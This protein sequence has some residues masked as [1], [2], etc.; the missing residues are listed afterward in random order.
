MNEKAPPAP[1]VVLTRE[2]IERCESLQRSF[3]VRSVQI[4]AGAGWLDANGRPIAGWKIASIGRVISREDYAAA[5][6]ARS[7][8]CQ[9]LE[10]QHRQYEL[11]LG[12]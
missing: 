7:K 9:R 11:A 1:P 6:D 8:K 10:N 12:G 3:T 2:L 4:L 5:V